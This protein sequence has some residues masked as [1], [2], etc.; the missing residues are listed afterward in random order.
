MFFCY[1]FRK[2]SLKLEHLKRDSWRKMSNLPAA[3][4]K[5][6]AV[7]GDEV[8]GIDFGVFLLK[9]FYNSSIFYFKGH[10][11]WI[12]DVWFGW[13]QQVK[14]SKLFH[15]WQKWIYRTIFHYIIIINF[16]NLFLRYFIIRIGRSSERLSQSRRHCYSIDC[17]IRN[18]L[19]FS[20]KSFLLSPLN[21][22]YAHFFF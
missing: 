4:S 11:Y 3:K 20:F 8:R 2:S 6:I 18:Q 12:F 17:S 5:L 22:I 10:S 1:N 15:L 16:K 7:V 13:T 19:I 14:T 21:S 9:Q